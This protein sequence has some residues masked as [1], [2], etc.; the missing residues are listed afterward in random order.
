MKNLRRA[1]LL[2]GCFFT[3]ML[4]FYILTG[5]YQTV[6]PNRLKSPADAQ[7]LVQKFRTIHVD[8]VYPTDTEIEKPSTSW[9]FRALVVV[10]S[11]AATAAI[12]LGLVLA[13]RTSLKP[14]VVVVMLALGILVPV[15]ALWLGQG[16]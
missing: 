5:W 16:R 11:V 14:W 3:P 9:A 10:M 2:L 15:I 1:H 13:F 6:N 7:T 8:Q 4:L 12:V